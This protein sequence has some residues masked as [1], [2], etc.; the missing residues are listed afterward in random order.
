MN[1]YTSILSRD[2]FGAQYQ[3][4][5]ATYIFCC[6]NNV[7]FA[8]RPFSYIE[9]NYENDTLF[10]DKI[11]S[12]INIKDAIINVN[13]RII[14][15]E[16]DFGKII[17]PFFEKNIDVCCSSKYMDNIKQL[18]W[19]NKNKNYYNN[20]KFN[21]AIHIRRDNPHDNGNAGE[22]VTTP[23]KHYL[24]VMSLIR[25]KHR[26]KDIMFHIYSQGV[27][28]SFV[29]FI[30]DDTQLYINDNLFSTFMG[31][32]AADC[33]VTSKSSL[34]YVAALIS[35]GEIYYTKFWH[36]PKKDWIIIS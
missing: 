1:Y 21:I 24:N 29:E 11:E 12:L 17:M 8:Y 22:R 28:S 9:H 20:N 30:N 36:G 14:V 16:I 5:I 4:I 10:N 25:E 23:N 19:T 32:V 6:M 7:Q 27:P 3:R 31:M 35:D 33:L 15:K 34:S 26:G 2:G 18:Y 13:N